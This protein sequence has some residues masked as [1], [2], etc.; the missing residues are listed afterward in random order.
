MEIGKSILKEFE[1]IININK[2]AIVKKAIPFINY[3]VTTIEG[4]K[5]CLTASIEVC[6]ETKNNY[7]CFSLIA[8]ADSF[9]SEK[10]K[11]EIKEKLMKSLIRALKIEIAEGAAYKYWENR[12]LEQEIWKRKEE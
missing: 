9:E 8:D 2:P 5:K 12:D 3:V 4:S 11:E 6:V 7:S 1:L 10:E